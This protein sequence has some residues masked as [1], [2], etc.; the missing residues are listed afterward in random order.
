MV[1]KYT[2]LSTS[3]KRLRHYLVI[4]NAFCIILSAAIIIVG[5]YLVAERLQFIGPVYGTQ[6]LAVAGYMSI[7]SGC[8][9]F[10][11]TFIGCFGALFYN[12]RLLL[13]YAV[14]VGLVFFLGLVAGVLALVFQF[15][16]YSIV[17]V[18]MK[19]SLLVRYGTNM[20]D[21]WNNFVT[22][23][24]DEIQEKWVCEFDF[25]FF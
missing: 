17:K 13:I 24:W 16:V 20:D 8:I 5:T 19:E 3:T 7:S 18:Y 6:L 23:S 21:P 1:S 2:Y 14:I 9:L 11:I 22:R 15:Q 12:K 4:A 25:F 10:L